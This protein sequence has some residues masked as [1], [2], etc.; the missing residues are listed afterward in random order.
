MNIYLFLLIV[1]STAQLICMERPTSKIVRCNSNRP[2]S[3]PRAIAKAFT[4]S[5]QM[6]PPAY[7]IMPPGTIIQKD[8]T[9]PAQDTLFLAIDRGDHEAVTAFLALGIDVNLQYVEK[10]WDCQDGLPILI[11]KI[12]TAGNTFLIR[13]A[14][15]GKTEVVKILLARGA[16]PDLQNA[17]K[18]TALTQCNKYTETMRALLVGKANPNIKTFGGNTALIY[19]IMKRDKA[20]ATLLLEFGADAT[21]KNDYGFSASDYA[22]EAGAEYQN[23]ISFHTANTTPSGLTSPLEI[24][25]SHFKLEISPEC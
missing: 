12:E 16:N 25:N 24:D 10:S 15:L 20:Q 7:P 17:Q 9:R 4:Q 2:P 21:I 8:K 22:L 14:G 19:S 1:S 18:H 3:M 6:M 5:I 13:A 11:N 23:L